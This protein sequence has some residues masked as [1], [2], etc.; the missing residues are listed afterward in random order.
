M[1]GVVRLL[2]ATEEL[3]E[4][5]EPSDGVRAWPQATPVFVGLMLLELLLSLLKTGAPAAAIGDGITSL[6]A[7]MVSR[8]P[9]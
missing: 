8:L 6:S 5:A 2:T 9:L 1:V 4:E 3:P 7:G